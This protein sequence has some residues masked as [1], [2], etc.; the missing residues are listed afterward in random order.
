[1][2]DHYSH[3]MGVKVEDA[4]MLEE[5]SDGHRGIN[6]QPCGDTL[7]NTTQTD[8]YRKLIDNV[9]PQKVQSTKDSLYLAIF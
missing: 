4:K 8:I 3:V 1:M 9:L 2:I 7:Y 5:L 6:T